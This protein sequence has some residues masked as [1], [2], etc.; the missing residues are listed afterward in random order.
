MV[1]ASTSAQVAERALKMAAASVYVPR[2]GGVGVPVA[3]CLS[4]RLSKISKRVSLR[5]LSNYCF[6]PAFQSM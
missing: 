6:F 5:L 2:A 4:Q 3:S 1:P